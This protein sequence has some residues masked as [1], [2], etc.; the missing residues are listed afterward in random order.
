M[1]PLPPCQTR[2]SSIDDLL[3]ALIADS[4]A[5]VREEAVRA[6]ARY[7][8]DFLPLIVKRVCDHDPRVSNAAGL[9]LN[10]LLLEDNGVVAKTK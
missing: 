3:L 7:S 2:A 10:I 6:A 4:S 8:S 9:S 1:G 5:R